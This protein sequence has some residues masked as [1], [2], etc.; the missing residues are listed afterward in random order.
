MSSRTHASEEALARVA[1]ERWSA[2]PG[3]GG[4]AAGGARVRSV[5]LGGIGLGYTL[6]ALLDA[7]GP[8]TTVVVTELV[9]EV[10][11]WVSGPAAGLAGRPLDDA[12]VRLQV[13][14]VGGR[15]AESRRAYDLILLD[16]D[17]GPSPVAHRANGDLYG[18]AGIAA[19][20]GALRA[21]GVL[22]VWSAGPDDR[23]LKRLEH[24]GFAANAQLVRAGPGSGPRHA[25]LVGVKPAR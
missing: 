15:I 1:I 22:A 19:C 4:P 13:G 12:R 14:D 20:H 8:D 21:G 6:R 11:R 3:R 18:D 23:Y 7:V 5:L 25:I 16:V 10:A 9:P 24:A 2:Q 17:N